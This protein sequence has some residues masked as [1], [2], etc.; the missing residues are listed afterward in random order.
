MLHSFSAVIVTGLAIGRTIGF[1]T[2]NLTI[3]PEFPLAPGVYAARVCIAGEW[4]PAALFFG[5][6][7]TLGVLTPTLEV[8]VLDADITTQMTQL[9]VQVIEKIREPQKFASVDALK[10]AIAQ[11]CALIR[12]VLR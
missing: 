4:Q 7:M 1:P 3:P 5:E 6:R 8:H 10:S 12:G 2:L 9:D 11:D